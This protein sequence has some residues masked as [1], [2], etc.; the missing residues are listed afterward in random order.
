MIKSG[1]KT[2]KPQ[3]GNMIASNIDESVLPVGYSFSYTKDA[4]YTEND[5]TQLKE[6]KQAI[7]KGKAGQ[8]RGR[9]V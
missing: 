6:I 7:K 2:V 4:N 5:K 9:K 3:N 1:T 8:K